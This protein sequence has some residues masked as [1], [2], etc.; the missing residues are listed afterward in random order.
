MPNR[1]RRGSLVTP[2]RPRYPDRGLAMG[3]VERHLIPGERV[4]YKTRL[5]WSVFLRPVGLV[6]AGLALAGLLTRV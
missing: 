2:G 6:I 3:Y 4:V 1:A 5:H